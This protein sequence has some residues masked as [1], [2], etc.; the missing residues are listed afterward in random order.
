MALGDGVAVVSGVAAGGVMF[1][2]ALDVGKHAAG[3]EA[4]E[5]GLQP[6]GAQF[7]FHQREPFERLLCGANAASGFEAYGEAGLQ[8]VFADSAGHYQTYGKSGV[9]GF[10]AGGGF[11]EV[12]AGHHGDDASAGDVAKSKEIAGAEDDFHVRGAACVF[13]SSDLVVEGL[14]FCGEDVSACDDYVDFIGAGLDR[15]ADFLDAL[16]EGR[17]AGGESSGDGGDSNAAAF[18]G[19]ARGFYEDMIDADGGDFDVE[20]FDAKLF[21]EFALERLAAFGAEAADAL[22]GVI[23]RESCEIHAGDG[24]EKP[25]G[26]IILFYGAAGGERLCATL[27][28]AGVDADVFDPIEVEW[29][30]AI[31]LESAVVEVGQG[32]VGRRGRRIETVRRGW[33]FGYV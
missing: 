24:A 20:R 5:V 31:R 21:Y 9:D 4:E 29:D 1:E 28:G 14:P 32:S 16:G 2:L 6:R 22:V 23:P 27:D 10:F 12:C 17:E 13:E 8:C 26:L 18:E 3:S 11:D 25:G 30:S 19:A 7:V 33:G 15:S